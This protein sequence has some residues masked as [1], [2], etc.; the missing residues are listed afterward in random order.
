VGRFIWN[1]DGSW[2]A[3]YDEV[4]ANGR[5]IKG[6]GVYDLGVFPDWKANI[7]TL[8]SYKAF[9]A[10]A[11]LRYV[12]NFRECEDN[13]CTGDNISRSVGSYATVD[14]LGSYNLGSSIGGTKL[15]VGVNNLLDAKPVKIYNGF[16]A[17]SDASTYDFLG[18]YFY[19]RLS[20]RM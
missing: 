10:G 6:K 20:H 18:R 16:L 3:A 12:D 4:Q 11:N 9:G 2:L 8:W 1:L 7:G 17:T 5:V 13:D 14:L 19:V 15:S